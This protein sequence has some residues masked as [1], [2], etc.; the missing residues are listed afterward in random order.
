MHNGRL[1]LVC[2]IRLWCSDAGG[3]GTVGADLDLII[4]VLQSMSEKTVSNAEKSRHA[5]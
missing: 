4:V 1:T 2:R 3:S 5:C